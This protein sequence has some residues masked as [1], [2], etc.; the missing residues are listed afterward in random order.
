MRVLHNVLKGVWSPP[1]HTDPAWWTLLIVTE[2]P[3]PVV[4][5]MM[6]MITGYHYQ[7]VTSALQA[8][9]RT[10]VFSKKEKSFGH[11]PGTLS[12]YELVDFKRFKRNFPERYAEL[13][14]MQVSSRCGILSVSNKNAHSPEKLQVCAGDWT[15]FPRRKPKP[16]PLGY[17]RS[18]RLPTL[19]YFIEEYGHAARCS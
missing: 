19:L 16:Y 15:L 13:L 8:Q 2:D 7:P 1:I 3:C 11:G 18:H 17:H 9:W 10:R 12:N 6:L 14:G 4:V 5:D